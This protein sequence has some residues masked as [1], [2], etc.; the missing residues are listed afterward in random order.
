MEIWKDIENSVG[1]YKKVAFVDRI[2]L[3]EIIVQ[4][5]TRLL[6]SFFI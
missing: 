4:Q 1:A 5:A 3:A 6:N 2:I